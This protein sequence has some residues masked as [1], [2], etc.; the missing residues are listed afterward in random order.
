MDSPGLFLGND[1]NELYGHP[2][3]SFYLF[4]LSLSPFRVGYVAVFQDFFV[5]LLQS[6]LTKVASCHPSIN[7]LRIEHILYTIM[8]IGRIKNTKII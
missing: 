6:P 1:D 8:V 5:F 2:E 4:L 3:L 7:P